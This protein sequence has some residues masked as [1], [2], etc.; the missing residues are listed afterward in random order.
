MSEDARCNYVEK[1]LSDRFVLISQRYF[2][3]IFLFLKIIVLF[4][5]NLTSIKSEIVV[6]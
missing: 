3:I 1:V 6:N 2:S 5:N 4:F